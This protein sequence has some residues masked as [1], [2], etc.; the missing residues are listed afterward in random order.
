MTPVPSSPCH[1]AANTAAEAHNHRNG[2]ARRC[3]RLRFNFP[4]PMASNRFG[5]GIL[6]PDPTHPSCSH[7]ARR[8]AGSR[9]QGT[10]AHEG[11]PSDAN[12]SSTVNG[13]R[14]LSSMS[15]KARK[16][17]TRK[18]SIRA[19][20]REAA[21]VMVEENDTSP[22]PVRRPH[23]R[24]FR[25]AWRRRGEC[26]YKIKARTYAGPFRGAMDMTSAASVCGIR[27][28]RW[29]QKDSGAPHQGVDRTLDTDWPLKL[30]S[31]GSY[32]ASPPR[33]EPHSITPEI[34]AV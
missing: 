8:S 31:A 10:T 33:E 27:P 22:P 34:D 30:G 26:A 18:Y 9:T 19:G 13:V 11:P 21:V 24:P 7:Y 3:R 12:T 14:F 1:S 6:M 15:R 23:R 2:E 25:S 32:P 5:P 29:N 16:F 20:C 4:S 17:L 28:R